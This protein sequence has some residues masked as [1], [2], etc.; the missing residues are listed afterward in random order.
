[1]T[2]DTNRHL[3]TLGDKW[4][5][6]LGTAHV[7]KESAALV[8]SVIEEERPDTVCI[9]LCKSRHHAMTNKDQWQNMDIL[10]VIKEKKTFVLLSN[11]MLAS[12]QKRIGKKLGIRPGEEM[13]QAIEAAHRVGAQIHLADRDIRTTL[14]RTWRL[15]GLWTKTKLLAHLL[16]SMGEVEKIKEEDVEKMKNQ[17][18]LETLLSEIGQTLPEIRHVLIDERDQYLADKIRRAPG[19]RIVAVVGAG[20]VSGIKRYWNASIDTDILERI[21]PRG[22]LA[23]FLK[24][25]VPSAIVGL[26]ILG[27]F[28]AGAKAGTEMIKWWVLPTGILAGLGAMVALA[29]PLTVLSAMA[30]APVTSLHPLI[31]AGWVAGLV[32]VLLG[33]PKVRDFEQLPEDILSAR[34]FWK[35]KITRILLVVAFT[36]MGSAL[37]TFVAIPLMVK[38]FA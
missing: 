18:V 28:F 27:F 25:A 33:K 15:M 20:H 24:W 26:M 12:F 8:T 5:T 23:T 38:A 6:L 29:H 9:E 16:V 13:L 21:P 31:A 37:G 11:L 2:N 17:D 30:A 10:K 7:S 4:V 1:M 22:R 14:A 32:E 3:L 19:N 36:N 34:G 35:N